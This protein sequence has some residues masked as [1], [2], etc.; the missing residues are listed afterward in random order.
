M[1]PRPRP[2]MRWLL[3]GVSGRLSRRTY[4]LALLFWAFAFAIPISSA[5][6]AV[7]DSA[8]LM[9]SG[10]GFSRSFLSPHGRSP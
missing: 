10:A 3:F 1:A 8:A 7:E 4:A 6:K 5:F 2:D 9:V